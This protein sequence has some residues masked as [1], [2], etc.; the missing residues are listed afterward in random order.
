MNALFGYGIAVPTHSIDDLNAAE[1]AVKSYERDLFFVRRLL[2]LGTGIDPE[3]GVIVDMSEE[4]VSLWVEPWKR[5]VRVR[6]PLDGWG[7]EPTIGST[8]VLKAHANYTK[9]NWKRRL[10]LCLAAV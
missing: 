8:V 2:T 6:R 3:S 5:I 4:K 10:T 7:F 1:K 9:R